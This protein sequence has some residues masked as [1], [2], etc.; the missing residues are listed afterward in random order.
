M[1]KNIGQRLVI[2]LHEH[3]KLGNTFAALYYHWSGYT[4]YSFCEA[5]PIA[6]IVSSYDGSKKKLVNKILDYLESKGG[7]LDSR[8][9]KYLSKHRWFDAGRVFNGD[10]NRNEGLLGLSP[11]CITD[12]LNWTEALIKI[13]VDNKTFVADVVYPDDGCLAE[14]DP[15]L[16][17]QM[18]RD[19]VDLPDFVTQPL[20][21]KEIPII[22]DLLSSADGYARIN[23]EYYDRIE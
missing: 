17:A 10:P 4:T 14:E 11:A 23:G 2:T 8:Q 1:N 12:M 19:C 18:K 9:E 13:D 22:Y 15:E 20:P 7:G 21:I 5:T 3:G 16:D 6:K